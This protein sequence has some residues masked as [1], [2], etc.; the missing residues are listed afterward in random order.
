M[1]LFKKHLCSIRQLA[2]VTGQLVAAQPGFW[3]A[4]FIFKRLESVKDCA[5][6]AENG[7]FDAMIEVPLVATEDLAWW[8]DNGDKF[9]FPVNRNK[10]FVCV[11]S[12]ASKRGWGVEF[13][14]K[15]TGNV[16]E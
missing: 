16:D 14:D 11:K 4:P 2:E 10:R 15:T 9:P 13:N 6:R 12:D 8:T 3:I 7:N 5:L 1:F